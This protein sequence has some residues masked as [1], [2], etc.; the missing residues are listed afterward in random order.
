[1]GSKATLN[2]ILQGRIKSR[3]GLLT[4]QTNKVLQVRIFKKRICS[5]GREKKL[6]FYG[7]IKKNVKKGGW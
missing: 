2:A 5:C 6:E 4:I 3:F 1:V 7:I